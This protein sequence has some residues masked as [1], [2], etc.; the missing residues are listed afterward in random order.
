MELTDEMI[1]EALLR[2]DE[3]EMS[4]VPKDE[5]IDLEFSPGFERRMRRLIKKVDTPVKYRLQQAACV[6]LAL[7]TLAATYLS[8]DADARAQFFGWVQEQYETL[9]HYFFVGESTSEIA[10]EDVVYR[11]TW[12]PD[13][14]EE[15]A[16][17]ELE[18]GTTVVYMNKTDMMIRFRYSWDLG[19]FGVFAN[20]KEMITHNVYSDNINASIFISADDSQYPSIFWQ[21]EETT[22]IFFITGNLSDDE[23]VKMAE[24]VD[25]ICAE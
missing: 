23:L 7:L 18:T 8:I 21:K 1:R 17:Y 9:V 14:Y 19:Y 25:K 3:I 13:G 12:L 10:P 4:K 6:A 2:Y 5:D 20:R 15:S 16:V 24:S 11:P 22:A